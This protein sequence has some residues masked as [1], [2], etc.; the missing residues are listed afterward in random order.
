MTYVKYP[1][2]SIKGA[3]ELVDCSITDTGY[4]LYPGQIGPVDMCAIEVNNDFTIVV[5]R[6]NIQGEEM[7]TSVTYQN[8]VKAVAD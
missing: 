2:I 6:G 5:N 4:I 8:Y 7:V 1:P 3:G